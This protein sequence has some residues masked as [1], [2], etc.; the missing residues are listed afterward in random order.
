MKKRT[1]ARIAL[2]LSAFFL[3]AAATLLAL[4]LHFQEAANPSPS[5]GGEP[6]VEEDAEGSPFP[7]VDWGYWQGVNPDVIGWITIPGTDVNHPIVQ[8]HASA[9]DYYLK[10]DVYKSYNPLGAIYLDADC[11][12]MGLSSRNAVI[13]GHSIEG[14]G[15]ATGFGIIKKY[16]DKGFASEHATVLVQTPAAKMTYEV[17]FAQIVKGWE[18]LKRTSFEGE[19]DFRSWYDSCR[20]DAA[21]AL[22]AESEPS[23]TVSLVSC[24]YNFWS[25]N[26]RG[27]RGKPYA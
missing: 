6:A 9:P 8:A 1:R 13:A 2:I 22:D 17:R 15:G 16:K 7:V 25:W 14:A 21:M 18:P 4:F 24:S 19:A 27:G 11:E 26:E 23:Q 10:H 20:A 12:D 5:P 3:A